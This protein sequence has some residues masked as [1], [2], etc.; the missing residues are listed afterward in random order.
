MIGDTPRKRAVFSS[1][2]VVACVE[3][4]GSIVQLC[5]SCKRLGLGSRV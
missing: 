1:Y 3:G 4:L 2:D 5:C